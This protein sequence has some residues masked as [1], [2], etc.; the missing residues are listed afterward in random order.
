MARERKRGRKKD[1]EEEEE[2]EERGGGEGK[3]REDIL[4]GRVSL[5][6]DDELHAHDIVRDD[7]RGTGVRVAGAEEG[8]LREH[9]LAHHPPWAKVRDLPDLG[10]A[11]FLVAS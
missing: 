2:E 8:T 3:K 9:P 10:R 6:E 4:G 7:S 11:G 1:G 5:A